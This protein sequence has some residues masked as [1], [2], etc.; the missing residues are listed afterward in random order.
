VWLFFENEYPAVKSRQIFKHLLNRCDIVSDKNS[1]F[2]RLFPNQDY[3]SGKELGNLIALPFQKK[4]AEKQ[5]SCF[6]NILT[7]EAFA[8][9]WEFL[10]TIRK[11][12]VLHLDELYNRIT[13]ENVNITETAS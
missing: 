12:S 7:Q 11:I 6:V 9:Q 2:D 5:N 1:S 8:D 4:A 10:K 13:G 3:H